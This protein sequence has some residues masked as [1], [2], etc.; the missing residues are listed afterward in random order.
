MHNVTLTTQEQLYYAY[1]GAICQSTT[2]CWDHMCFGWGHFCFNWA[3]FLR[4]VI[5]FPSVSLFL[6]RVLSI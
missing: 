5:N 4:T 3:S 6:P 1:M 2:P